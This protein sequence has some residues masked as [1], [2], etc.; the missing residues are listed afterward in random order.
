MCRNFLQELCHQIHDS[1]THANRQ[2]CSTIYHNYLHYYNIHVNI[3]LQLYMHFATKKCWLLTK[4]ADENGLRNVPTKFAKERQNI[5]LVKK[6]A[7]KEKYKRLSSQVKPNFTQLYNHY[8]LLIDRK[9]REHFSEYKSVIIICL[10]LVAEIKKQIC[11]YYLWHMQDLICCKI[12]HVTFFKH[13]KLH[14]WHFVIVFSPF[15]FHL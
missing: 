4:I 14:S 13:W 12:F 5:R 3:K 1:I 6:R 9:Y 8:P 11:Q 15:L 7:L 2:L 10:D